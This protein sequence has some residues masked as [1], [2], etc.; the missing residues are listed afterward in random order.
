MT[1]ASGT[2]N[3]NLTSTANS[4]GG[5]STNVVGSE[6]SSGPVATPPAV[7]GMPANRRMSSS[8]RPEGREDLPIGFD[9]GVLRGLCDMDVSC[10]RRE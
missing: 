4:A 3:T 6:Q 2:P 9:E 5:S 10:G 7:T 8:S 1:G